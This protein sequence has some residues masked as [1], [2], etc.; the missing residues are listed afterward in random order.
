MLKYIFGEFMNYIY[1]GEVFLAS[2]NICV[3]GNL[4]H[5]TC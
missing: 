4:V 1:Y 2:K 3:K 5:P